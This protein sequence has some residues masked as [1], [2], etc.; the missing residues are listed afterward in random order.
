MLQHL[1]DGRDRYQ[2]FYRKFKLGSAERAIM[3]TGARGHSP[4]TTAGKT[5]Q[6]SARR[7]KK[8]A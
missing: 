5:A 6:H 7:R 1:E 3:L 2:A 8:R 4:A